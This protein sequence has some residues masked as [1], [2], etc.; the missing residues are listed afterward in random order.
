MK[1]SI[2]CLCMN[3]GGLIYGRWRPKI[4]LSI[5]DLPSRLSRAKQ[6]KCT[7]RNRLH[8]WLEERRLLSCEWR[9]GRWDRHPPATCLSGTDRTP[10][11]PC[12]ALERRTGSSSAHA[13]AASSINHHL[14]QCNNLPC[15]RMFQTA[16]WTRNAPDETYS[17]SGGQNCI[18]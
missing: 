5:I 17:P 13:T 11:N 6:M 15:K 1:T 4:N 12:A 8:L 7:G 9:G 18:T 10:I 14:H 2:F 16:D 3:A